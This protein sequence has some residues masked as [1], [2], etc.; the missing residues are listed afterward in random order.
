MYNNLPLPPTY[1]TAVRYPQNFWT[2]I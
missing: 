2:K 1:E